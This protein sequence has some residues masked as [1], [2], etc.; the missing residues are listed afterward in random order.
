L[1]ITFSP[2]DTAQILEWIRKFEF[3]T[4]DA[5]SIR[6]MPG[7]KDQKGVNETTVLGESDKRALVRDLRTFVEES[8]LSIPKVACLM[9][10]FGATLSMWIAGSAKPSSTELLMIKRF[11]ER[12]DFS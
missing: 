7:R 4:R 2:A 6:L 11:L 8:E 12:R 3:G 1:L 5:S 10:V 9:G